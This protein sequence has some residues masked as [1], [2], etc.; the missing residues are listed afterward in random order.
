[1]KIAAKALPFENF[2]ACIRSTTGAYV[3]SLSTIRG[4]GC[5]LSPF[6]NTSTD[7]MSFLG[8]PISIHNTSIGPMSF[9]GVPSDWCHVPSQ[10]MHVQGNTHND[11]LRYSKCIIHEGY[12]KYNTSKAIHYA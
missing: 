2:T 11:Y 6:H 10:A 3:F 5:T 4:G 7:S 8:V 1:M 12:C 9:L